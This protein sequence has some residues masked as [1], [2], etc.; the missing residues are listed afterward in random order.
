[1]TIVENIY[2]PTPVRITKIIEETPDVKTFVLDYNA[3]HLPGQFLQVSVLGV[4]EA[5][6]SIA[7]SPTRQLE[8]CVKKM[9]SVTTALHNLNENDYIGI[10]GP[11]GKP[12]PL[13]EM[14][15]HDILIV[16]G[17]IGL[18]PLRSVVDFITDYRNEFGNVEILYGARTPKDIVYKYLFDDWKKKYTVYRSVDYADESWNETVGVVTVL[19]DK[20]SLDPKNTYS[21]IVGP[22]IMIK[23]AAL[24]LVE[25]GF[26]PAKIFVSLERMMKCGVGTCGHCNIGKFY[27]CKDGPVFRY[28]VITQYMEAL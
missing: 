8:I 22:P 6:I 5:P 2:I 20:I 11:Y 12:F 28:S 10:R 18:P 4:G 17:G 14:K 21:L 26:D 25:M 27:V 7:S 16:G 3:H 19:F 15:G 9:G 13:D 24:K 1:M 23:Y